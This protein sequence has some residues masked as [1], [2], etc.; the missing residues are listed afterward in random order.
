MHSFNE[1]KPRLKYIQTLSTVEYQSRQKSETYLP[2][3][4]LNVCTFSVETLK[5][6]VFNE[7]EFSFVY[8][9]CILLLYATDC[10]K[11]GTNEITLF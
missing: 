9:M 5:T 2:V 7:R 1:R 10:T 11:I 6:L 3:L 8:L 4:S